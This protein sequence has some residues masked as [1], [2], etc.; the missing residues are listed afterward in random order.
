MWYLILLT[1][2]GALK[3]LLLPCDFQIPELCQD[4]FFL[5]QNPA[6]QEASWI[7]FPTLFSYESSL[8]A[9]WRFLREIL[10]IWI[11]ICIPMV[12]LCALG[13]LL[14]SRFCISWEY[15]CFF[16]LPPAPS[17]LWILASLISCRASWSPII[18][19]NYVFWPDLALNHLVIYPCDFCWWML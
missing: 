3:S 13:V 12:Y 16:L 15:K 19:I 5:F 14:L 10:G 17:Q 9:I 6:L 4:L 2:W 11:R 1:F 18:S 8:D 7:L